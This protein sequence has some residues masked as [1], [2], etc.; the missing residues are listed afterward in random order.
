MKSVRAGVENI[1]GRLSVISVQLSYLIISIPETAESTRARVANL[2]GTLS[3][4][5]FFA[6]VDI[7]STPEHA[8]KSMRGRSW[9]I[10]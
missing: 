7:P 1:Q 9:T 4:I 8:K 5:L 6:V 2:Q 10:C 3:V